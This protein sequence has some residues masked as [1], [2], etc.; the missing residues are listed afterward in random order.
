MRI[1]F[2]E[3]NWGGTEFT[4][5]LMYLYVCVQGVKSVCSCGSGCCWQ[6]ICNCRVV[7]WLWRKWTERWRAWNSTKAPMMW[8]LSMWS[9]KA[10]LATTSPPKLWKGHYPWARTALSSVL[11][12]STLSKS[13]GP[14]SPSPGSSINEGP[15][16]FLIFQFS[17]PSLLFAF[18][19]FFLDVDVG[20]HHR[21]ILFTLQ[22]SSVVQEWVFN[23]K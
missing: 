16:N 21:H 8:A 9:I 1:L 12:D 17:P 2:A 6:E 19:S 11:M 18:L 14:L 20:H 13:P 10:V 15:Y 3:V 4:N 22:D 5:C 23:P 7:G